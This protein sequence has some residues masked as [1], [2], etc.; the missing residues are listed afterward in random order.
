MGLAGLHSSALQP[1][2]CAWLKASAQPAAFASAKPVTETIVMRRADS[3]E[4]WVGS[5]MDIHCD[6][7]PPRRKPENCGRGYQPI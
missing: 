2:I 3:A 4:M 6:Q 5:G 1:G 7:F